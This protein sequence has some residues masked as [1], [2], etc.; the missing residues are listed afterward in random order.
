[1]NSSRGQLKWSIPDHIKRAEPLSHRPPNF[2]TYFD[3][4]CCYCPGPFLYVFLHEN[5]DAYP[6]MVSLF[7]S[8]FLC[9]KIKHRFPLL[10]EHR[11]NLYP[12]LRKNRFLGDFAGFFLSDFS[13]GKT[14]VIGENTPSLV[15]RVFSQSARQR[16]FFWRENTPARV[17]CVPCIG[18][19]A[20]GAII[21]YL[22]ARSTRPRHSMKRTVFTTGTTRTVSE[23]RKKAQLTY[24]RLVPVHGRT[25]G[26]IHHQDADLP[27]VT[28]T[29]QPALPCIS[30]PTN[31]VRESL[32]FQKRLIE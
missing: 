2:C 19:N 20:A 29:E 27:K 11:G 6:L 16:L 31:G 14:G 25:M 12:N 24:T 32:L 7:A 30:R 28:R 17:R 8:F 18:G 9:H 5:N 15:S 4:P 1:V 3:K 13:L 22:R 23:P 26:I 10:I 21:P